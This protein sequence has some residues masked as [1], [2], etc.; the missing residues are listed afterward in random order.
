MH[1]NSDIAVRGAHLLLYGCQTIILLALGA[2][3]LTAALETEDFM[4]MDILI[5]F[6]NFV[7]EKVVASDHYLEGLD[8]SDPTTV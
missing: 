1:T 4:I 7:S 6:R 5:E 3:T 8:R 2:E